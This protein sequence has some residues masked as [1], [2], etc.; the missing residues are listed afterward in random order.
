MTERDRL[1]SDWSPFPLPGQDTRGHARAS[2]T[3]AL[4]VAAHPDYE[5][6]ALDE[7]TRGGFQHQS[8]LVKS[9]GELRSLLEGVGVE[10]AW[11]I[12]LLIDTPDGPPSGE[13]LEALAER[14]ADTPAI[15]IGRSAHVDAPAGLASL[16]SVDLRSLAAAVADALREIERHRERRRGAQALRASE[17]RFATAFD[18]A[19]IGLALVRL[20]GRFLSVNPV[21]CSIARLDRD[22][23][24]TGTPAIDDDLLSCVLAAAARAASDSELDEPLERR[25]IRADGTPVW[26]RVSAS[27]ASGD[28][29]ET[30]YLVV[31]VEDVTSRHDA[32]DA[33]ERSEL[34]FT[35]L[36]TSTTVCMSITDREGRYVATNRAFEEFLGYDTG[37]LIGKTWMVITHPD[38]VGSN[39]SLRQTKLGEGGAYRLEKRYVRKDGSIVWGELSGSPLRADDERGLSIGA[40]IDISER[41]RAESD[42][43]RLELELRLAQKLEAVGQLAAGIA[44]EINTPAQFVGDSLSFLHQAYRDVWRVLDAYRS[45]AGGLGLPAEALAPVQAL[46]AEIDLPYLERRIAPAFDRTFDGVQRISTIVKA[47]RAFSHPDEDE[48]RLA[49]LNAALRTSL[50]VARNEYRYVA[51]AAE[52]LGDLP[53]VHCFVGELNQV[54]LNLIVNAAHAIEDV[55]DRMFDPFFTTKEVGRG[56][57]QGLPLARVIVVERHGG[58]IRFDTELGLGTT[59]Q[60]RIPVRGVGVADGRRAA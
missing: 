30:L 34:L 3:R 40:I 21:F 5:A 7:L 56:T 57:G 50:I 38:D 10:E 33:Q 28:N 16:R 18:S 47:M 1:H 42:R 43:D 31:H 14:L 37:E 49:D 17:I 53:L 60:L 48:M 26:I 41:K 23:I 55:R 19:P 2:V 25:C 29:G 9:I 27:R 35:A 39:V 51:T 4:V 36:F 44:H 45:L 8:R 12:V 20:D 15:Y 52:E 24:V 58:S 11:D 32:E 54:F 22:A 59:F 46:E 6:L 13:V